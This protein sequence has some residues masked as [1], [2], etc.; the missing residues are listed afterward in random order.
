MMITE[1]LSLL[2]GPAV[3]P[4]GEAEAMAHLRLDDD[5]ELA[6][7]H[8]HIRAARE[9]V[10]AWTGRALISQSWRLS[11]DG[12]PR[13]GGDAW[14]DGARQG[15]MAQ[16]AARYIEIP[17]PPLRSI[18][19]VALF[20]DADQQTVWT[21]ANYYTDTQSAP[22]RLVLRNT[23][24]APAPERAANGLQI[25]FSCGYGDAGGDVPAALRQAVLMLAAHFFEQ[26]EVAA[27]FSGALPAPMG[28]RALLAPYRL[29]RL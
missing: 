21:A 28:A 23:S 5:A 12:W 13:G 2:S 7:V 22:G 19:L 8:G 26:R 24:S 17:K 15:A 3:E 18:D 10:E 9:F 4:V 11:L 20:N 25:S 6:L 14:W 1:R 16:A 29:A 27:N